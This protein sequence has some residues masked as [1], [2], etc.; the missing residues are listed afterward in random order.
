MRNPDEGHVSPTSAVMWFLHVAIILVLLFYSSSVR[1]QDVPVSPPGAEEGEADG[2]K[3]EFIHP[4]Q[5]I[6][7]D[8]ML[9][10]V[11]GGVTIFDTDLPDT[12]NYK[13]PLCACKVPV[14]RVGVPVAYWNPGRLADVTREEFCFVG[15]G[16]E[17][18]DVGVGFDGKAKRSEGDEIGQNHVHWYIY[19]L[20]YWMDFLTDILCLEV[21][22]FDIGYVTE[23][24]PM[25]N[26]DELSA[27][28]NPEAILFGTPVAQ[29][30]CAV[31]CGLATAGELPLNALFWCAGCQ[32]SLYPFTGNNFDEG[33]EMDSS[34][35]SVGRMTAKLHRQL[36]LWNTSG[37]SA[38]AQ[39]LKRPAPIIK[40][41]QYRV[42]MAYP[43]AHKKGDFI[44]PRIGGS[45]LPYEMGR[46]PPIV[47][48]NKSF[49]IWRK[50]NCCVL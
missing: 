41:S 29:A 34:M 36:V 28:I 48:E 1:A 47:G 10:L 50:R 4:W 45:T 43:A 6:C 11:F 9:P 12:K 5:D 39:C 24:D 44:C 17:K 32:G 40:K 21:V 42:Q 14:A 20:L 35:L 16:G 3:G 22:D 7:W 31:D 49:V 33:T 19:P 38:A 37:S 30:A 15:L 46:T 13:K 8:C 27:L 25:W 18:I 2:C 23:L 26:S